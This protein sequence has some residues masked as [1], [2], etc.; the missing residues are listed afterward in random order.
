[1]RRS[2]EISKSLFDK[3]T[4]FFGFPGLDLDEKLKRLL[5]ISSACL[6]APVLLFFGFSHLF[7]GDSFPGWFLVISG[8][9]FVISVLSIP[10]FPKVATV[11]R[12]DLAFAGC[13]FIYLLAVSG[14]HGQMA[15]WLYIYPPAIFFML[16]I[17]EGFLFSA[18]FLTAA[19]LV[20]I[21]QGSLPN[22]VLLD[23]EFSLR[24]FISLFLVAFIAFFYELVRD[25]YRKEIEKKQSRLEEEKQNLAAAKRAAE[26]ANDKLEAR[27]AHRTA[28]LQVINQRL[29][30]ETKERRYSQEILKESEELYRGLVEQPFDGVYVQRKGTIIY[31]NPTGIKLLGAEREDQIIGKSILDFLHPDYHE[32]VKNRTDVIF[33]EGKPVPLAEEKFIRLDGKEMTA[34]VAATHLLYDGQPSV[35]VVIRDI[36]ERKIAEDEIRKANQGLE[37]RVR[38]RTAE[39]ENANAHLHLEIAERKRVEDE[40]R[41]ARDLAE[42]ANRSK[43]AFL[44]NMSHEL[45]TPLNA[46]L[47]FSE[48]LLDGNS[49]ELNPTQKEY[50]GDVLESSRHLLSLINDI[51]DLSKVEAGK[52]ELEVREIFL[53]ALLEGSLVMVGEKALKHGIEL[54]TELDGV[55]EVVEG[56]ERKLKQV[57]FNL[58]SNAVKFTPDGGRVRIRADLVSRANGYWVGK[59]GRKLFISGDEGTQLDGSKNWV[60][61]AVKDTGIGIQEQDLERIFEPFEQVE[62]T[63]SRKYQ[64]TGLGL[65]LTRRM[66]ELHG[67]RIWAESEGL[68]KG[69]TFSFLIPV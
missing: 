30:E 57:V 27:V 10:K 55:P 5:A 68:G 11:V 9:L 19:L 58:L 23:P 38:E 54:L 69:S 20:L 18:L 2:L 37:R 21:F 13:L 52:M 39:L 62:G 49:G 1:M 59:D 40:L 48:L 66:V 29:M 65:S 61:V 43:S 36:T 7:S 53:R 26:E 15:M 6:I 28:E 31:I 17:R 14:P 44:A 64:G 16:G 56:D 3:L 67:G 51:L 32:F 25:R 60:W 46:I 24:F 12:V 47:G 34:E 22:V 4:A 45:R 41:K 35:Q 33:R 42:T 8:T 63:A 50:L